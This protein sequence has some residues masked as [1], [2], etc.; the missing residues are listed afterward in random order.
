MSRLKAAK[1]LTFDLIFL[2][3]MFFIFKNTV[4]VYI[5]PASYTLKMITIKTPAFVLK[6]SCLEFF[7]GCI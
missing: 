5:L 3:I 7:E 6:N 1:S 4:I 2:E